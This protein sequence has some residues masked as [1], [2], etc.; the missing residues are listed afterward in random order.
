[1]VCVG[2]MIISSFVVV[3]VT[4]P[5]VG[6]GCA[7]VSVGVGVSGSVVYPHLPSLLWTG[8]IIS[9][10]P[11]VQ[12]HEVGPCGSCLY[13]L[14]ED[15]GLILKPWLILPNTTKRILGGCGECLGCGSDGI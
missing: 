13:A 9:V 11:D 6:G 2:Q 4:G 3:D 12:M 14:L 10:V 8:T 1:M 7:S 15:L 5:S